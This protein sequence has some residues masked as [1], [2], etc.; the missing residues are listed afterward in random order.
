MFPGYLREDCEEVTGV[1]R[2]K[3]C[4]YR[5]RVKQGETEDKRYF[6]E[7]KLHHLCL[8]EEKMK[9]MVALGQDINYFI[10]TYGMG[11]FREVLMNCGMT[12]FDCMGIIK[13]IC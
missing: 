1:D 8:A 5:F 13:V 6:C 9:R 10:G 12:E 2:C 7:K 3:G 4:R 11:S